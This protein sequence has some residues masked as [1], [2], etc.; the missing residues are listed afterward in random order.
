VNTAPGTLAVVVVWVP[1]PHAESC[2]DR[3]SNRKLLAVP[4]GSANSEVSLKTVPVGA[5]CVVTTSGVCAGP[6][7]VV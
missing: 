5:G 1:P 2:P 7:F 3:L 4:F 6:L